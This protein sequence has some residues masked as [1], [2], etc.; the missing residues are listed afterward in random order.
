[1][2][3]NLQFTQRSSAVRTTILP[4]DRE[5]I[6]AEVPAA[7][8]P[9]LAQMAVPSWG[10]FVGGGT[11]LVAV[12]VLAI[13]LY[14]RLF[15]IAIANK[16]LVRT[17]FMVGQPI[18]SFLDGGCLIIPG[19]HKYI[20]V[21]LTEFRIKVSRRGD[22]A[23]RTADY[24]HARIEATLYVAVKKTEDAVITAARR[25]TDLKRHVIDEDSIKQALETRADDAIRTASKSKTLK[26]ID[27]DKQGFQDQ[28][29]NI[30]R[31]DI[32]KLGLEL[33]S[34]ALAEIHEDPSY[35]ESNFFDAQG[36][37]L[38][39]ETIQQ[40]IED[41][42]KVELGSKLRIEDEKRKAALQEL[43]IVREKEEAQLNQKRDIET[44]RAQKEREA[45]E[46]K[47]QE[48]STLQQNK[49]TFQKE[50]EQAEILKQQSIQ[51]SQK[52]AEISISQKDQALQLAKKQAELT[53]QQMEIQKQ[54]TLQQNRL[55]FQ[56]EVEQAEILKQ[57]SIQESQKD[58]EISV[59]QKDQALQLAKK[60]AELAIQQMEVQR[61][62]TVKEAQKEAAIAVTQKEKEL[63]LAQRLAA[64]EVAQHEQQLNTA[65]QTAE[66]A[67]EQIETARALEI[68]EREQRKTLIAAQQKAEADRISKE[69]L[70]QAE[71]QV[72]QVE[73]S[74][75]LS[76]AQDE[77]EAKRIIAEAIKAEKL[78]IAAGELEVVKTQNTK[79]IVAVYEGL[80]EKLGP[81]LIEKLPEIMEA[82]TPE[83]GV[84]GETKVYSFAGGNAGG[85]IAKTIAGTNG[86]SVLSTMLEENSL[87]DIVSSITRLLRTK[88]DTNSHQAAE[89]PVH[90]DHQ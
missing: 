90:S 79:T 54:A 76:A 21:P 69:I 14:S 84:L 9:I 38:R 40:A 59:S 63:D 45:E 28:V 20:E 13:V 3:N 68:A 39:T 78:A 32:E 2:N 82:L 7:P 85:E 88:A 33:M 50:V 74:S 86:L 81:D 23:V 51:E 12:F 25:L 46:A 29:Y 47:A 11:A 70:A 60:Q 55:T 42:T 58:A 43:T 64:M 53:V 66:R 10:W 61:D 30:L 49:L 62:R 71:A 22:Q 18:Q 8:Q 89:L 17:G 65:R 56:K 15:K 5:I 80:L 37:K 44:M 75:K 67:K 34:V 83:P 4:T 6:L 73:A 52:D 77:A 31:P 35:D 57:Q 36:V 26:E 87:S 1:M 16:A 72:R 48:Q 27:S 24:L 41:K 19:L